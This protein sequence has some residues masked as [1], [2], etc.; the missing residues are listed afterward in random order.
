M[1][2]GLTQTPEQFEDSRRQS[3]ERMRKVLGGRLH[4]SQPQESLEE[5]LAR[6]SARLGKKLEIKKP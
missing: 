3:R 4:D 1:D 6:E 5:I 2:S